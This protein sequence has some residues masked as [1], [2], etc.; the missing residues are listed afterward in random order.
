VPLYEASTE[1]YNWHLQDFLPLKALS[2]LRTTLKEKKVSLWKRTSQK[3]SVHNMLEEFKNTTIT[4]HLDLFL[5]K[6]QSGKSYN[7]RDTIV[8]GKL[9]FKTFSIYTKTESQHCKLPQ[10]WGALSKA[11][12][13]FLWQINVDSSRSNSRKLYFKFLHH[14]A[15]VALFSFEYYIRKM[16]LIFHCFV[17]TL[18]SWPCWFSSY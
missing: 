4:N 1:K 12:K 15:Q 10:V 2:K 9:V 7:Y 18:V 11:Q 13:W 3:F 6:T 16:L 5:R 17:F 8:F 14:R